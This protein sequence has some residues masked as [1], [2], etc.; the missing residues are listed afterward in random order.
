MHKGNIFSYHLEA[1]K[2]EI[3]NSIAAISEFENTFSDKAARALA[4][5]KDG[6]F[7]TNHEYE[8]TVELS[9][10]IQ[11]I[12]ISR[13]QILIDSMALQEA[14]IKILEACLEREFRSDIELQL[15]EASTL[16]RKSA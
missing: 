15:K 5:R 3:Q 13:N 12:L 11:S 10:S 14:R 6:I 16:N 8:C 7:I 2:A 1:V 9:R 4:N